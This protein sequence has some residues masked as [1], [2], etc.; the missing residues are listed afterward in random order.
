MGAAGFNNPIGFSGPVD[1]G[2]T[3]RT[4]S[5]GNTTYATDAILS[6]AISNGGL[7]K[8]GAGTL[9]LGGSSTYTGPTTVSAGVLN[10]TG[11]ISGSSVTVAS[12]TTL[13]QSASGV[14]DGASSFTSGKSSVPR[15]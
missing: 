7:I 15:T 11:S 3:T 2:A 10:L 5:V 8:A 6:G 1:L 13:N 4:I 12:G 14:I 9:E